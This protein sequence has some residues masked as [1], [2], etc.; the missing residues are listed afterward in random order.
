MASDQ[1]GVSMTNKDL[2]VLRKVTH[3]L[4][5]LLD[6]LGRD[7]Y[8]VKIGDELAQS[9]RQATEAKHIGICQLNQHGMTLQDEN[10]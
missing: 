8:C 6:E 1:Q 10:H 7:P 9:I 3:S 4:K 5:R 2:L